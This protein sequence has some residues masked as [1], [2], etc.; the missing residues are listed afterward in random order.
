MVQNL[1]RTKQRAM[2]HFLAKDFPLRFFRFFSPFVKEEKKEAKISLFH[3]VNKNRNN[4]RGK[5][6]LVRNISGRKRLG[7]PKE[8]PSS[9]KR[10]NDL[11]QTCH[12]FSF[13]LYKTGGKGEVQVSFGLCVVVCGKSPPQLINR[14]FLDTKSKTS[15]VKKEGS[16]LRANMRPPKIN[17]VTP[18]QEIE[19][20]FPVPF[21]R[22]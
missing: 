13:P 2:S 17:K 8:I 10:V 4:E 22:T 16:F 11:T 19:S 20:N 6:A 7:W 9:K 1:I 5:L 18:Y 21:P 14:G 12:F 3:F 15:L